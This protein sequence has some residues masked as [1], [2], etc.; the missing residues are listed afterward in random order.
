VYTYRRAVAVLVHLALWSGAFVTAFL[1]RF[2]FRIPAWYWEQLFLWL[3]ASLVFRA[4]AHQY[5]GLF[6]GL[7]R[8]TGARDLVGLFKAA[9]VA[10]IAMVVWIHFAGPRGF[11]R[12]VIILDWLLG[13]FA[14][15]GLRFGIR[16]LREFT[17]QV[18][19]LT[20]QE[21]KKVLVVGAGDA[22]EML[23]RELH[24]TYAARFELCGV[25]D[26]D[27]LK[28]REHLHG[29]P[30]LG[31]VASVPEHVKRLDIDEIIIAMPSVRGR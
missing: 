27:P 6:R 28:I 11:P 12:S 18:A 25:V 21:R 13:I 30:V 4:L 2:E 9:T 8:Y 23:V 26:D 10:T 14:V 15:G 1:L 31:P 3:P 20:G 16:T 19:L 5:L 24:K 7:W 17:S 22:G 29:V